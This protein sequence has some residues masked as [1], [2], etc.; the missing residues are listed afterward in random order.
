MLIFRGRP[1]NES[2]RRHEN[3]PNP[4]GNDAGLAVPV[5]GIRHSAERDFRGSSIGSHERHVVCPDCGELRGRR[6]CKKFL[7]GRG[8]GAGDKIRHYGVD[9]RGRF[10]ADLSR[11]PKLDG[12]LMEFVLITPDKLR[13]AWPTV[14][15]SLDEVQSKSPEDWIAED[16]YHAVKSGAAALHLAMEGG[17]LAGV[18][19]T[20]V[21][22]AEFSGRR[23]LHVWVAHNLGDSDVIDA[24]LDMLR[25]MAK[26]SG[27]EMITFGSK[28]PGWKSR[29]KLVN[30]IYGIDL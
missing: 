11:M 6:L 26:A 12:E 9:L 1:Q 4:C 13:Q 27:A 21:T 18:L 28:R 14:R 23:F 20:T 17:E 22:L 19:I 10:A 24:G 29:H 16:V 30:A 7:A 8:R 3:S 5:S 25:Q 2:L 15:A